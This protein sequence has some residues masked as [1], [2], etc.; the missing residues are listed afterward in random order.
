MR[1]KRGFV[2]AR[3]RRRILKLASGFRGRRSTCFK[4]AERS[5]QKAL[6]YAYRDRRAKKREFRSLWIVRINAA[7]RINGL[8]Y[9]KLIRGLNKAQISLDRK[10]LAE[11]AISQPMAFKEI[12]NKA[13]AALA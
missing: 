10:S 5:V 3:S 4:L 11:L 6:K 9:S 8:T 2:R 7:C 1:V 12:A 13:Q